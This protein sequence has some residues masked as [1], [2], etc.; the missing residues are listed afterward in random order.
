MLSGAHC[1]AITVTPASQ[2]G[3]PAENPATVP[4]HGLQGLLHMFNELL[5][6]TTSGRIFVDIRS[7]AMPQTHPT[8]RRPVPAITVI[9]GTRTLDSGHRRLR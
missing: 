7:T 8:G 2:L 4:W 6:H 9:A 5:R 1:S 3:R